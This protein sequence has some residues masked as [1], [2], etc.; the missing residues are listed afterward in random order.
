V[1][2]QENQRLA[3][4]N[5]LKMAVSQPRAES[6][7]TCHITTCHITTCITVGNMMMM[8]MMMHHCSTP[9]CIYNYGLIGNMMMMHLRLQLYRDTHPMAWHMTGATR[10]FTYIEPV[11]INC[12]AHI[13]LSRDA[14]QIPNAASAVIAQQLTQP[15]SKPVASAPH[16]YLGCCKKISALSA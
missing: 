2:Q 13:W 10:H 11:V 16:V 6:K 9:T 14:Q 1:S 8:M 7:W 3:T 4:S 12:K 15:R 5:L